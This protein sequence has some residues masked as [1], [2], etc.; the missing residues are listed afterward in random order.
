MTK[1]SETE[2]KE[3]AVAIIT[4]SGIYPSE[5]TLYRADAESPVAT[6]LSLAAEALGLTNTTDW[7]ARIGERE[8]NAQESF[9]KLHL[10]CIVDIEWHKPEGGGGA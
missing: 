3:V 6:V 9:K 2:N 7:V 8:I 1:D 10:R 4:P 5:D